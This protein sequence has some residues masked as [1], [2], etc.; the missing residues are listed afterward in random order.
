MSCCDWAS[1]QLVDGNSQ[2]GGRYVHA[3]T[4]TNLIHLTIEARENDSLVPDEDAHPS[5]KALLSQK[6]AQV[7]MA[8]GVK[9][10]SP[11]RL[12]YCSTA[13]T[14]EAAL[15]MIGGEFT[16]ARSHCHLEDTGSLM[17]SQPSHR[18]GADNL[19]VRAKKVYLYTFNALFRCSIPF[20]ALAGGAFRAV[21]LTCT[22]A[23]RL[24]ERNRSFAY[25]YMCIEEASVR[26]KRCSRLEM[27]LN[28]VDNRRGGGS[29][30]SDYV[31]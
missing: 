3:A 18:K 5:L 15:S 8:T 14:P 28:P 20:P 7:I 6:N 4:S 21:V 11:N 23:L 16:A 26:S 25:R 10:Q 13:M 30:N 1:D 27:E 2:G 9:C 12:Q 24:I 19:V 17:P 31:G 22:S 29:G